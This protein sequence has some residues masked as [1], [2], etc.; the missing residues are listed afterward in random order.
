ML[1][2]GGLPLR[3]AAGRNRCV[4]GSSRCARGCSIEGRGM[5]LFM[6]EL[7]LRG[8][9]LSYYGEKWLT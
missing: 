9:A 3:G 8:A 7:P 4:W 5:S 1:F 2:L 6:G